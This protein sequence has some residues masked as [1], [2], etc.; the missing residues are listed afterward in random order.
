MVITLDS[1]AI[2]QIKEYNK[3]NEYSDFKLI[4]ASKKVAG[5]YTSKFIRETIKENV[6][7][8]DDCKDISTIEKFNKCYNNDN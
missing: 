2:K 5:Y 3:N 8:S 6:K 1:K 4:Q 7:Y